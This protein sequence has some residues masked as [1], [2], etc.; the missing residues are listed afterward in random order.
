M[1]REKKTQLINIVAICSFVL[2]FVAALDVSHSI[3]AA[4]ASQADLQFARKAAQGGIA[5]VKFGQLAQSKSENKEIQEFGKRMETDH[6]KAGDQLR[7]IASSQ[8]LDLP[9]DMDKMS[10]ASYDRLSKLS[11][12]EFD[13]AY[14]K[15]MVEDHQKDVSEFQKEAREGQNSAVKDF[16]AQTLPT[17]EQHLQII[18]KINQDMNTH[19]KSS[20]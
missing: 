8:S 10:Q 19:A 9:T 7:D 11:G 6:G 12:A 17:I 1:S 20:M 5:E 3:Y 18:R 4:P 16:A 13:R 2:F 14:T 15:M